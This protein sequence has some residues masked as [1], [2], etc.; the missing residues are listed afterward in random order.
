MKKTSLKQRL[1]TATLAVVTAF[2]VLCM[3]PAQKAQAAT[4]SGKYPTRKGAILVTPDAYKNLIPTGH[5]AIVVN[6][7]TVVESVSNG[8]VYGKNNWKAT[9]KKV[10]GVSVRSTTSKQDAQACDWCIRQRG[11]KYNINY[12]NVN[13]RSKFYCSQLV[14]AAFKDNFGINLNTSQF[15][16]A[17][18]PMELVNTSK[19]YTTYY[20]KR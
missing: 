14:W 5:A 8:V 1:I 10:Y 2:S 16:N 19:T 4:Q 3:V 9:K 11:K 6:S 18:H 17:I 20:Y 12:F 13:T 15:G 7:S